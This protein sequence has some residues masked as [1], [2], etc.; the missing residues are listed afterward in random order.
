MPTKTVEKKRV[1][2]A[3]AFRGIAFDKNGEL[4]EKLPTDEAII[5]HVVN[6]TGSKTFDAKMLAWYKSQAKAGKLSLGRKAAESN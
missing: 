5:K 1:S 6:K 2:M 3:A 4:K